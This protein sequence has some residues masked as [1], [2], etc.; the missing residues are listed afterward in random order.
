MS[1]LTINLIVKTNNEKSFKKLKLTNT[2]QQ[3]VNN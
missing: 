2:G 3:R 1:Y